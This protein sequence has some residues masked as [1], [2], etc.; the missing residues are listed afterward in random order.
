MIFN[1]FLRS[2]AVALG[3][4]NRGGCHEANDHSRG[5]GCAMSGRFCSCTDQ[6]FDCNLC[7]VEPLL[8]LSFLAVSVRL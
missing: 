3:G 1:C 2:V 5:N 8:F 6:G 7:A 4:I